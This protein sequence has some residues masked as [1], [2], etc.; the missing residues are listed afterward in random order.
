MINIQIV[1]LTTTGSSNS[2][3]SVIVKLNCRNRSNFRVRA[4]GLWYLMP[5]STF[6]QL[7]RDGQFHLWRK[8]EYP[9]KTTCRKSQIKFIT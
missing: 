5:L 4:R 6:F 9:E 7:Y 3:L 2:N 1:D 8:P